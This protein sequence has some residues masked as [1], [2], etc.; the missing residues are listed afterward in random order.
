MARRARLVGARAVLA[1]PQ[2][3]LSGA[4]ADCE[5]GGPCGTVRFVNYPALLCGLNFKFEFKFEATQIKSK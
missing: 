3:A 1:G 4:G 2:W 5:V